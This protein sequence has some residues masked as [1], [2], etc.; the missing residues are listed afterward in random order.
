MA[1]IENIFSIVLELQ[2]IFR[3]DTLGRTSVF[4]CTNSILRNFFRDLDT[5][6]LNKTGSNLKLLFKR[7]IYPNPE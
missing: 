3:E 4:Y 6:S 7:G 2:T 5:L 1:S